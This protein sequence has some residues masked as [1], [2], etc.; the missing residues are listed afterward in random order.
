MVI[1]MAANPHSQAVAPLRDFLIAVNL[2][3]AAHL[4]LEYSTEQLSHFH[5]VFPGQ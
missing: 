1:I 2:R 5:L 3:T 4:G